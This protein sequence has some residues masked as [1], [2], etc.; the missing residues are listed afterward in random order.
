MHLI[1]EEKHK[2]AG[3]KFKVAK[4]WAKIDNLG[5]WKRKLQLIK[6]FFLNYHKKGQKLFKNANNNIFR[7]LI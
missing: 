6:E 7:L 4:Y 3:K 5:F 2:Q 1:F